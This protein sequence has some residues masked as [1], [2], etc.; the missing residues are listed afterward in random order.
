MQPTPH[1][2]HVERMVRRARIVTAIRRF[3][4]ERGFLE[5]DTPIALT[6]P[7]PEVHIE[8][9]RVELHTPAAAVRYL[10]PSPELPMKRLLARGF[11]RIY[12]VA[13]VFRDG[14]FG[15]MH[16]P[17]FRLLEWYRRDAGWET[18]LDDC[19]QLL[20]AAA[21]AAAGTGG[22]AAAI[23]VA[24]RRISLA[25]PFRR[26]SVDEAFQAHAG[27]SILEALTVEA[28]RPLVRACGLTPSDDD[29]WSDL[30]H[31]VYLARVEPEL[32]RDGQPVFL[33]DYPAPL[34]ALARLRPDDP[35]VAERFELFVGGWELANGFGELTAAAEQR[36][37]FE[38]DRTERRARGM[39]DDPLDER[40]L[41]A[42]AELPP[43]AGIALGLDRLLAVL[44]DV[45]DLD[46]VAFIPWS[47]A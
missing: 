34:S 27:F 6:A 23:S 42:L 25:A 26:L 44:L 22:P 37:R 4:D 21:G 35:R 47:E 8:A 41:D 38:A 24:G 33:T 14:D 18:L 19:E 45:A 9:P 31:R 2:A 40:V 13:P 46:A 39:H 11:A 29:S 20:R 28:L 12:Q 30:F 7:A 5:V 16:R 32:V 43:S 1:A 36:R 17:E 3:F 15:P 10:Q